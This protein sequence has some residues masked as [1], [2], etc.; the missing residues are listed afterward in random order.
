MAW[1][2]LP[3]SIFYPLSSSEKMVGVPGNAPGLGTDLV[4][5]RL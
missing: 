5:F 1:P 4:R 2:D 3:S